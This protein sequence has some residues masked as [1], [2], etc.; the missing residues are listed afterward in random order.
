[1]PVAKIMKKKKLYM[2]TNNTWKKEINSK[3]MKIFKNHKRLLKADF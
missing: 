2:Y 1:M 3:E